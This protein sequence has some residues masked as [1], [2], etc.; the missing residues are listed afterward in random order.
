MKERRNSPRK[1]PGLDVEFKVTEGQFRQSTKILSKGK[2]VDI[3]DYG[4]GLTTHYPLEKG[5]VITIQADGQENIPKFGLVQ[6]TDS[7]N[8]VCRAGFGY[9]FND[10]SENL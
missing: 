2:I 10:N 4:F 6:W 8:G 1:V 5:Q 9:K 3:S 7:Y